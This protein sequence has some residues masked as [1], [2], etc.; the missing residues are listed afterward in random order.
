M[1]SLWDALRMNM[2]ISYQELVRTFLREKLPAA[3]EQQCHREAAIN[4]A[5]LGNAPTACE[6]FTVSVTT[7]EH[8]SAAIIKIKALL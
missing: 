8:N 5:L 1:M 6:L 2:M 7:A 3:L 4:Q